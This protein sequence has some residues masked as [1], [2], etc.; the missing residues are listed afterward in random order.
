MEAKL[1][2][3]EAK[4]TENKP[5]QAEKPEFIRSYEKFCPDCG[6]PNPGYKKPNVFCSSCNMPMG[7]KED[8]EKI[9]MCWNC[10]DTHGKV[11][12]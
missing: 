12:E 1:S 4:E 2:P 5:A 8:V 9:K 11:K 10:G 6:G 7:Q 3:P